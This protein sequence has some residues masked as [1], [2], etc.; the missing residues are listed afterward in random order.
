MAWGLQMQIE[1]EAGGASSVRSLVAGLGSTSFF[2]RNLIPYDSY[3]DWTQDRVVYDE[4]VV[5]RKAV[6]LPKY[7]QFREDFDQLG[8]GMSLM[9]Y[10]LERIWGAK[11]NL[12]AQG[13]GLVNFATGSV[14]ASSSALPPTARVMCQDTLYQAAALVAMAATPPVSVVQPYLSCSSTLRSAFVTAAGIAAGNASL[15]STVFITL[16]VYLIVAHN[17]TRCGRK[18]KANWF[19]IIAPGRKAARVQAEDRRDK[20]ALA[21]ENARLAGQVCALQQAVA[22]QALHAQQMRD[23]LVALGLVSL[24]PA[25]PSAALHHAASPGPLAHLLSL[26][27]PHPTPSQRLSAAHALP[28]FQ[29][30]APTHGH[31]ARLPVAA[32]SPDLLGDN[33]M[34]THRHSGRPHAQA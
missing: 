6:P 11:V 32:S 2:V 17:N 4:T 3:L 24:P 18:R 33:P 19:K 9:V 20:E 23:A 25:P 21:R 31:S 16:A 12:N 29:A 27:Q 30:H 15:L 14:N 8:R 10:S 1:A 34:H 7:R 13:V 26:S 28:H 5:P 22:A